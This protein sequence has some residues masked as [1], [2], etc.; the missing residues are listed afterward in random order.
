MKC[1]ESIVPRPLRKLALLAWVAGMTTTMAHAEA[2]MNTDD[3]GTLALNGMKA[4]GI[5]SKDDRTKGGEVVLGFSPID[6]LELAVAV[7]QATDG[8]TTP[9]TRLR[10]AGFGAKWVPYQS[11][12]GWSLG[13]RLDFGHMRIADD[14]TPARYTERDYAVTGLASWRRQNG[15]VLHVNLGAKE[16]EPQGVRDTVATWGIGYEIPMAAKLKLTAETFGEEHSCPD[17]AVGVRYEVFNGFKISG[18]VGRGNDRSFGQVGVA[19][20]F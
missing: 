8:S 2:P 18:A 7:S 5:W 13:A 12:I 16:V 9:A 1:H 3:A 10:G 19:W 11:D 14:E 20:E 15:Q 17:K 4:E 6:K